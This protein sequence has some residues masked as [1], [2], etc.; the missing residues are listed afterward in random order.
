MVTID[1]DWFAGFLIGPLATAIVALG[2][3]WKAAWIGMVCDA[4]IGF[5]LILVALGYDRPNMAKNG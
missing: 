4:I 5:F 2:L 1:R 3:S